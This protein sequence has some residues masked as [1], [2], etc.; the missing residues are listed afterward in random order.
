MQVITLRLLFI[1]L[2]VA[3]PGLVSALGLGNIKTESGLNQPFEARIELLSA[4]AAELDSLTVSLADQEAF[5][6][7]GIERLFVLTQLRFGLQQNEVG[8][9]YIRIYS[10]EPIREPYLNF[11]IEANW[12]KGRIFREY[13]VLLDP[14]IYAPAEMRSEIVHPDIPSMDTGTEDHVVVYGPDYKKSAPIPVSP[15]VIDYSGGDY[16]PT[17]TGDT[18]WSLASAMRPDHSVSIQQMMFALLRANP[19]AFING[20]INGLLRGE[21]LRMPEMTEIQSLSKEEAFSQA[22]IQ[23]ELWEDAR[24]AISTSATQRPEGVETA[25]EAEITES[26]EE[27]VAEGVTTE[28]DTTISVDEGEPELRLV[29]PVEEVLGPD[30]PATDSSVAGVDSETLS[31][32]LALANESVEALRLENADL[33]NKLSEADGLITDLQRYIELKENELAL[34]QEQVLIAAADAEKETLAGSMEEEDMAVGDDESAEEPMEEEEVM[35]EEEDESLAET[36]EEVAVEEEA[37]SASTDV[38]MAAEEVQPST[39]AGILNKV[40][41]IVDMIKNNLT[42]IASVAAGL[43]VIVFLSLFAMRRRNRAETIVISPDDFPDFEDVADDTEEPDLGSEDVTDIKA[44]AETIDSESETVVPGTGEAPEVQT[45]IV[46][47]DAGGTAE[48]EEDPMA[49]VNVF[50][51]YEHFDQAEDFVRQAIEGDPDN[52]EYHSKLLEVFYAAGDKKGYEEAARVLH[53]KVEGQGEYWDMA[54]V[55]WQELSPNR[56]LFEAPSDEEEEEEE[57]GPTA[58]TGGGIV[59]ITGV[60]GQEG[61]AAG[62]DV[63]DVTA[64]TEL[65]DDAATVV[66][67]D[68]GALDFTPESEAQTLDGGVSDSGEILDLTVTDEGSGPEGAISDT[69]DLLDVTAAVGLD[70]E[71][72]EETGS[73]EADDALDLSFGE[74]AV[75]ESETVSADDGAL[76]FSFGEEAAEKDEA[77]SD[78]DML[79]ISKDIIGDDNEESQ[80]DMLDV[81]QNNAED[82]LDVTTSGKFEPGVEED[83]LDVTSAAMSDGEVTV[84]GNVLLDSDKSSVASEQE[85][86][87]ELELDVGTTDVEIDVDNENDD[88]LDLTADDGETSDSDSGGGLDFDISNL[89]DSEEEQPA[90]DAQGLDLQLDTGDESEEDNLGIDPNITFEMPVPDSVLDE[91]S[92]SKSDE[93]FEIDMDSTVQ[94]PALSL[95]MDEEDEDDDEQETILVPRSSESEEQSAEDEIGTQLDLAKAYIELGDNDNAKTIL[96]EIVA[97]GNEEQKQQAQDML[98]Q[99]S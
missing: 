12:S 88:V 62:E 8:P 66:P 63:L 44:A 19:E 94:A 53:D 73:L 70:E 54:V 30:Q 76:D 10:R 50:L 93:D 9:D 13:T 47:P 26:V 1:L 45:Q 74:E 82:L 43:L 98:G 59:D 6:R 83:L 75:E 23:N 61:T 99:I 85:S 96:D 25:P 32:E 35:A 86:D 92:Q 91:V 41:G 16:G 65:E 27:G 78:E 97:Q 68:D 7:A 71:P 11:L 60:N 95:S 38:D 52:L 5:H 20:N 72:E 64:V 89:G 22:K 77:S 51:A 87:N 48:E 34:L 18:L 84:G 4:T 46:T 14:P 36:N 39:T 58:D 37:E 3:M 24:I 80:D 2:M 33:G 17:V 69:E 90:D 49:E 28:P 67:G 57:A 79:D 21:I 55:M 15:R 31:N 56:A 29:V 42:I 81:S 40:M